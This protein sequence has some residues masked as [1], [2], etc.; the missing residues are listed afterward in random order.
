VAP[1]VKLSADAI[2]PPIGERA[3]PARGNGRVVAVGTSTGGTQALERVLTELTPASPGIVIVQHMPEQFTAAF[4]ERLNGLCQIAVKEARNNDPVLPGQALI[5]PGGR[6][7]L[8]RR[9]PSQYFVEVVD[10]PLV[11]RHRP[12]ALS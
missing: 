1:S 6:H 12:S 2:L 5:A 3:P 10:G 11:N 9:G 4:A 8:L 7:M